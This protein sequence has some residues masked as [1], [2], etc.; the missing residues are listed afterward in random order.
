[1]ASLGSRELLKFPA[2]LNASDTLIN[3]VHFNLSTLNHYNYTYHS[4][5]T[6]S[7]AS[8][9]WLVFDDFTPTLL[10]NGTFVNGTSCYD[11]YYGIGQRSILSIVFSCLF[12]ASVV[13]TTVNLRK[14]GRLFLPS[15]KRFKAIGRRWQWYWMFFVAACGA[16]SG[17]T[18]IDIDRDYLQS[19]SLVLQNF[20]YF[21]MIPSTLATVWEGVRHWGSWQERQMVDRDA[22]SL[23]QEGTRDR[24]EFWMPLIFYLFAFLVSGAFVSH[25]ESHRS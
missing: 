11:P 8:N 25:S 5:K 21:L 19:I 7:N 22:F 4:N 16:I 10:S 15:E 18:G 9:C 2:G 13:F 23:P 20:F 17:F 12:L 3:G 24:K 14:H 1:M 6:L